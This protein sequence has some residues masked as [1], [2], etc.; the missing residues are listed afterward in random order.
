M[1]LSKWTKI[2]LIT[3]IPYLLYTPLV[4]FFLE[5]IKSITIGFT[6]YIVIWAISIC[7]VEIKNK[8]PNWVKSLILNVIGVFV[9]QFV[10]GII[11]LGVFIATAENGPPRQRL[12]PPKEKP[13]SRWTLP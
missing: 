2:K 12:K 8:N 4:L 5:S 7:V 10:I 11:S 13:N 6:Y 3:A 9:L 1:K